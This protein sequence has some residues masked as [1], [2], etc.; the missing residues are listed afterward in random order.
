MTITVNQQLSLPTTLQ[1]CLTHILIIHFIYDN[2]V[3]EEWHLLVLF[4]QQK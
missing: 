3:Y 1:D 4:L 2:E